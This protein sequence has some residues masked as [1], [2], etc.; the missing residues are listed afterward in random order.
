MTEALEP[1]KTG[2]LLPAGEIVL[3]LAKKSSDYEL[4]GK[5]SPVAFELSTVDE[6]SELK[7]LSVWAE[8]LTNAEQAL[9]LMGVDISS[10]PLV[11]YLNVDQVR[12]L[13]PSPDS[14]MVPYLDVVWDRLMIEQ[15]SIR[16]PDTRPG[17][18]G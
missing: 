12:E 11:I 16:I 6:Q 2:E 13:R 8:R 18:E 17:A 4:T 5:A 10:Y 3:R 9:E 7:A 14:P 1:G 15:G